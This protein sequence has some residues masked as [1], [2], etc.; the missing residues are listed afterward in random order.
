M[1][2]SDSSGRQASL[3]KTP[4]Y[5]HNLSQKSIPDYTFYSLASGISRKAVCGLVEVKK[6]ACFDDN[7]VCQTIGYHVAEKFGDSQRVK[8]SNN[9]D[10]VFVVATPLEILFCEDELRFIFFPFIVEVGMPLSQLPA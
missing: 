8:S 4:D 5:Q 1:S 6:R 7:A 10:D 3:E 9:V 2:S